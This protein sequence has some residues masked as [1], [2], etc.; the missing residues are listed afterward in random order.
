MSGNID[1]M[2]QKRRGAGLSLD[3][4]Y[5]RVGFCNFSSSLTAYLCSLVQTAG[6]DPERYAVWANAPYAAIYDNSR[7]QRVHTYDLF[8]TQPPSDRRAAILKF[9]M[10]ATRC[11]LVVV[12][13]HSPKKANIGTEFR[14]G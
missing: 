8:Q 11:D 9:C 5:P 14:R 13:N 12:C 2:F 1:A 3:T 6:L 10:K 7:F 4:H